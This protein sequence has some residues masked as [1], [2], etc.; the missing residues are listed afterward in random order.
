MTRVLSDYA[1]LLPSANASQPK[2]VAALSAALQ[3]FVEVQNTLLGMPADFDIDNALGPQLDAVG[4]RVGLSRQ[5]S[6]PI[7]G[8]YFSL[9]TSGVGLDQGVL[10]GPFD[11]AEGLTSLD[12]ET[13]RLILKI[14][15]KANSW[16]GSL[17]QAQQMLAAV[18]SAGTN[19]F[20]QDMFDMSAIIGVSGTVPSKLFVSILKQMKDWL[21]PSAVN[22]STVFVT[23]LSGTPILGLDMQNAYVSGLDT[24]AIATAY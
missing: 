17:A 18:A 16:D 22:L 19:L 2:F 1:G 9:D 4:E 5:V 7:A 6:V 23:S 24:G 21:R 14:K 15:V 10:R 13:Y 11:P 3:P 12:D 8:V 20:M